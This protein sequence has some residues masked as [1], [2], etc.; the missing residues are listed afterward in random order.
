MRAIACTI[1]GNARRLPPPQRLALVNLGEGA[2]PWINRAFGRKCASPSTWVASITA[3]A[4][5]REGLATIR[6][7]W[8]K[9]T[10]R[11]RV[12]ARA[13]AEREAVAA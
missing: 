6:G 8:L 10:P 3:H 1:A 9:L 4:L 11:G 7:S 13:L 5:V 12:Y 2:L